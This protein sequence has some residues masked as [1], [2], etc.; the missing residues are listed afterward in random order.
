MGIEGF[1]KWVKESYPTA[2]Y[3]ITKEYFDNVYIDLNY[4]LHMCNYNSNDMKHT[5]NKLKTII[6]DINIKTQP[7]KSLNLFCDGV[8]PLAKLLEQRKRRLDHSI[9]ESEDT[10]END[11]LNFTP[12]TLFLENLESNLNQIIKIIENQLCIKINVDI[13][14]D[15]EGELKIKNALLQNYSKSKKDTHILVTT[16]A[17]V[18]LMAMSNYSYKNTYIL[19][20]DNI[21]SLDLLL[22]AHTKIFGTSEYSH[23]DF[24]FLNLFLGN[25]Y[26]PK[27][28][29]ISNEKL[30]ES[31]KQNLIQHKYL[32]DDKNNIN[33]N[34]LIDIITDVIAKIK[35][36]YY[37][38]ITLKDLDMSKI[39]NYLDGVTWT[40]LM[41][42]RGKCIDYKYI[43][44]YD[45]SIDPLS[46]QIYLLNNEYKLNIIKNDNII[47]KNLCALILLPKR[48]LNLVDNKYHK[49]INNSTDKIINKISEEEQC[50]QCK[51]NQKSYIENKK[52]YQE[53]KITKS[54]YDKYNE[55]YTNHK[56]THKNLTEEDINKIVLKFNKF[57]LE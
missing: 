20:K 57:L 39:K 50:V 24:S 49:F 1:Y 2:I 18:I 33:V 46:L 53:E 37:K 22:K 12:G 40:F 47:N 15:G 29:Y 14:G 31:Y 36:C 26:I 38:K 8:A 9:V 11:Y 30:W 4:L 5:I 41:Y 27:L 56:K 17:D 16:D 23:L 19:L 7:A 10:T 51:L 13:V 35:I 3:P 43:Y 25:D 52:L 54:E 48:A 21:L 42:K 32:I 34:F 44:N 45:T 28:K 55:K 6:L